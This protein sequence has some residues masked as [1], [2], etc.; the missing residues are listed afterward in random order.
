M[1][2]AMPGGT[3]APLHRHAP[4]ETSGGLCGLRRRLSDL[5]VRHAQAAGSRG[6]REERLAARRPQARA[7]A[8]KDAVRVLAADPHERT[9][10]ALVADDDAVVVARDSQDL[11]GETVDLTG[12]CDPLAEV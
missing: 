9:Y 7:R 4:A 6:G 3:P 1:R 8:G 11:T 2:T 5:E 10:E 12:E